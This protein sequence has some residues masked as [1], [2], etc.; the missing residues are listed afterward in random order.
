MK[1]T[2]LLTLSLLC[3][4]LIG[5]NSTPKE[6]A[7]PQEDDQQI[8]PGEN[9]TPS[10]GDDTTPSQDDTHS[11][12]YFT[13][14]FVANSGNGFMNQQK[15]VEGDSYTLPDCGFTAPSGKTFRCWKINGVSKNPGDVITVNSNV[16][17]TAV[18]KYPDITT[19]KFNNIPE[20]FI[21]GMDSSCVPALEK[22]GVKFYNELDEEEDAY[23]ILADHGVNYIR[24]RVWN[25]PYDGNG[26]G[27]GGGNCDIDNALAIGKRATQ[28][29]MKLLVD[30]HYSDFWADPAKQTAPKAWAD[31]TLE[32]KKTALYNY[33][34]ESLQLFK[35]NNVDVG[36]VQVGNETNQLKMAGE[37]DRSSVAQ[38]MNQGSKA[39][40]E[41]FPKALVA[42]HF[43]DPQRSNFSTQMAS[44]LS[45]YAVDYDVF[46]TSYYPYWHG[47]LA[48]LSSVL[49]TISS[50]YNKK[51][52]VLETSYAYTTNDTDVFGNTS[53]QGSDVTPH[54]ISIQGQYDQIYDVIDTIAN[55]TTNG[56]GVCYWE[57]TWISVNK[58]SWASNKVY[59]DRDGSGWATSYA[60][61]YD[62]DA[63]QTGGSAVDN[64]A[65]F[66]QNGKILPSID[67]F[68]TEVDKKENL[69][70]NASFESEI[71]PW[72]QEMI[73]ENPGT[74]T[75]VISDSAHSIG[76]NSLNVWGESAI[77]FR[78]KQNV[79][80]VKV[81]EHSLTF[82]L[83]GACDNYE[84]TMYVKENGVET[85]TKAMSLTGW[86]NWQSYTLDF[87]STA[88]NIEVG[89]HFS[90]KA[91]DGWAYID[92]AILY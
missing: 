72:E 88:Q 77:E 27:Y 34:K 48:N 31:Y 92:G 76:A 37:T 15:V 3:L 12:T 55:N 90:F 56:L 43:T 80:N 25:D 59:W 66:D 52:M 26:Y 24:V 19:K 53:P 36:M 51:V 1:K 35:T 11:V 82:S 60:S 2:R 46:G 28:Y 38:L 78:I 5:C 84:I 81:G 64:Q 23:K 44:Y 40:R 9:Q 22:S 13:I 70:I 62:S 68:K 75:C 71:E 69:L 74:N 8:P 20:D 45:T 32:Q 58:G 87:T 47:T 17:V 91:A 16:L 86:N 50:T 85:A 30:F 10:G 6:D 54:D 39:I 33:T 41:V 42:V 4:F 7:K 14:S 65:F 57:G 29:G 79:E 83:M 89:I 18:W 73:T 61:S 63:T 21:V 67:I 49:S